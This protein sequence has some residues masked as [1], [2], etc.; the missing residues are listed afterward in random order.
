MMSTSRIAFSG[1][2]AKRRVKMVCLKLEVAR[3]RHRYRWMA[4][5][6]SAL[7][8]LTWKR[9]FAE[10]TATTSSPPWYF[11]GMGHRSMSG[12]SPVGTMTIASEDLP[13]HHW[14]K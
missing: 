9:R 6:I 10:S 12:S 5:V 8:K 1:A 3:R 7:S 4:F 11:T 13:N 2:S 14:R